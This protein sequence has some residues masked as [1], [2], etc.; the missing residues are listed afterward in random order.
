[1]PQLST[2]VGRPAPKTRSSAA[3]GREADE[4]EM[5]CGILPVERAGFAPGDEE[6]CRRPWSTTKSPRRQ[7]VVPL[8]AR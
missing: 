1:M 3:L 7:A 2:A 5:A 8:P 4:L 6:P